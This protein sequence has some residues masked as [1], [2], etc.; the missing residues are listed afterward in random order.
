M[1]VQTVLMTVMWTLNVSTLLEALHV[2]VQLDMKLMK[3][4]VKVRPSKMQQRQKS[5]GTPQDHTF[6]EEKY[7]EELP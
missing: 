3:E 1:N 7:I 6:S 4:T 2:N 5:I